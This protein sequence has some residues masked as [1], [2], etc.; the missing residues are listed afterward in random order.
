MYTRRVKRRVERN[1]RKKSIDVAL[2]V[3]GLLSAAYVWGMMAIDFF[4]VL[5]FCFIFFAFI[6]LVLGFFRALSVYVSLQ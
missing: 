1:P 4:S 3:P 2:E 5:D 6:F